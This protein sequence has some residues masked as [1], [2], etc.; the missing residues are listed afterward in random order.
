MVV[1]C[2]QRETPRPKPCSVPSRESSRDT[3]RS[4]YSGSEAGPP[5]YSLSEPSPN[6]EPLPLVCEKTQCIFLGTGKERKKTFSR[7][8]KMMDHVESHLRR[9]PG[10]TVAC[11]HP[12]YEAAGQVLK[13]VNQ[14]KHRVH[15]VHGIALRV[16]WYVR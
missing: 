6:S 5:K 3:S 9:E 8:A 16:P 10:Q 11:R 12:V 1:L 4:D 13:T 14:F 15:V 2:S 7:P